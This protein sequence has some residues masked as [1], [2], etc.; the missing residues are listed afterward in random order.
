MLLLSVE[1]AGV[2]LVAVAMVA[3]M[4]E[5]TVSAMPELTVAAMPET[6]GVF[7]TV[8]AGVEAAER[9]CLAASAC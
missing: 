6:V 2:L 7:G 3:A 4:P 1:A 8:V 5:L 9:A